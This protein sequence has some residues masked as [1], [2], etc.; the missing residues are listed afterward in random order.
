MQISENE[1]VHIRANE[2]RGLII[3]NNL[4]CKLSGENHVN[5]YYTCP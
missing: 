1:N 5:Q 4:A 2:N 3:H